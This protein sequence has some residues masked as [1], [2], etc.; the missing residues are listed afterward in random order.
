MRIPSSTAV[1]V[2]ILSAGFISI[3]NMS[4]AATVDFNGFS[5]GDELGLNTDLGNGITAD[6]SAVG[7]VDKAVVFDTAPGTTSTGNDPDLT[8]DFTNAENG[9]DSRDFGKA[10]IIQENSSGGPDDEA[11]GGTLTFEFLNSISLSSVYLLDTAS[12]T[13]ATL[14]L[15]DAVVLSFVLHG[16]NESDTNDNPDNNEF[17][18]LNFGGAIGDELVIGFADSGAIGEF[19]ATAVPLP[20]GLPLLLGGLGAFANLKRRRKS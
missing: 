19:E 9:S 15:D 7:G 18:L 8:S 3:A 6:I 14:K 13:T 5:E 11:H 1:V 20:A 12:E 10:L 4:V 16:T 2:S 17:T